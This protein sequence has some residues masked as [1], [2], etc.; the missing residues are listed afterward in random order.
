MDLYQPTFIERLGFKAYLYVVGG[1]R[2]SLDALVN[3]ALSDERGTTGG[4]DA[5]QT[6]EFLRADTAKE[7]ESEER[8]VERISSA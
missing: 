7:S 5:A 4:A 6:P 8:P 1:G 3:E 2:H